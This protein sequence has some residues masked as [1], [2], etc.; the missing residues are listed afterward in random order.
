MEKTMDGMGTYVGAKGFFTVVNGS[1]ME[2][3]P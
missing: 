1:V 3:S 2:R